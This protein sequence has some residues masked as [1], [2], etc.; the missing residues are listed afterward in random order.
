[1]L[2]TSRHVEAR[3]GDL[4]KEMPEERIMG[5]VRN[6]ELVAPV[7][8]AGNIYAWRMADFQRLQERSEGAV[9]TTRPYTALLLGAAIPRLL[10][11]WLEISEDDR[12]GRLTGRA[13]GRDRDQA[14]TERRRTEDSEDLPYRDFFTVRIDA[15]D[16]A[17][18]RVM[19]LLERE[20]SS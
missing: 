1:M 10:P 20:G 19:R 9:L 4:I 6:G 15:D 2:I 18:P 13:E 12:A 16:A 7:I 5:A 8:F 3:E 11:V 14:L 17:L